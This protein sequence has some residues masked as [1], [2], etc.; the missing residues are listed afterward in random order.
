M[1][2]GDFGAVLDDYEYVGTYYS[3]DVCLVSGDV[4]AG[5]GWKSGNDGILFTFSVDPSTGAITAIDSDIYNG[6]TFARIHHVHGT[7]FAIWH[8]ANQVTTVNIASDG[9][10]G[11]TIGDGMASGTV[12]YLRT[13]PLH[14][15]GTIFAGV[16]QHN[17]NG[18]GC[19]S[20]NIANDGSSISLVDSDYDSRGQNIA[21]DFMQV[22]G[23][24]YAGVRDSLVLHGFAYTWNIASNGTITK[25][26]EQDLGYVGNGTA[27]GIARADGYDVFVIINNANASPGVQTIDIDSSGNIGSVLDTDIAT[28]FGSYIQDVAWAGEDIFMATTTN[29][30]RSF[31]VNLT[32]GVIG[33][34]QDTLIL[35]TLDYTISF[36][37][38]N[39]DIWSEV[40]SDVGLDYHVIT[41][42]VES[43]LPEEYGG[44]ANLASVMFLNGWI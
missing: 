38:I 17:T 18:C 36:L 23:S 25:I 35:G 12:A 19:L 1:A 7:V 4:Y 43:D 33:S 44:G 10:I 14:I 27:C 28:L 2:V 39:E 42:G 41:F 32:T 22:A 20:F 30:I 15:T 16:F 40:G 29:Y 31:H 24:V 8:D 11:S 21:C 6:K 9:T 3:P 37:H 26:D 34:A 5:I 13:K